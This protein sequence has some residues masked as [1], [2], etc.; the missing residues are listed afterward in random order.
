[1]MLR[2]P[3]LRREVVAEAEQALLW[4]LRAAPEC[5]QCLLDHR[6]PCRPRRARMIELEI[7]VGDEP[8]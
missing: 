6:G 2:G 3:A 1:M 4:A 5:P 8:T 7:I